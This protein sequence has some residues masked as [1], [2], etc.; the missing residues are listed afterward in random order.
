MTDKPDTLFERH[1]RPWDFVAGHFVDANKVRITINSPFE[2]LAD[3]I[4]RLINAD[5]PIWRCS[6]MKEL[7]ERLEKATEGS[8]ELDCEIAFL[9]GW[10][11]KTIDT[12]GLCWKKGDW[13]WTQEDYE[14]PPCYTTSLDAALSLVPRGHMWA[15]VCTK[16]VGIEAPH[17]AV[18][19]PGDTDEDSRPTYKAPTPALALCIAALKA[20]TEDQQ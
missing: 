19:R 7:I 20:R 11:C 8:R 16:V 4:V 10:R 5:A 9:D 15:L 3:Q 1:P 18:V 17:I 2:S 12:I 6:P 14:H 13:S